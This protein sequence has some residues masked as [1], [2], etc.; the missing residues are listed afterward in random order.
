MFS[1]NIAVWEA[2]EIS[3]FSIFFIVINDMQPL[4]LLL[5]KPNNS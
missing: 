5:T 1:S 3:H 4:L 2:L